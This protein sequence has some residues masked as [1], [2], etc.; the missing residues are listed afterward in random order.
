MEFQFKIGEVVLLDKGTNLEEQVVIDWFSPN[1]VFA[2]VHTDQF[3]VKGKR[4]EVYI[5]RLSKKK[6]VS[7]ED[8]PIYPKTEG[9]LY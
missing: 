2:T 8:I 4:K 9:D 5:D 1:Q 7:K 3:G 6:L